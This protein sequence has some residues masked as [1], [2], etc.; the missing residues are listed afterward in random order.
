MAKKKSE[1]NGNLD[2]DFLKDKMDDNAGFEDLNQSTSAIPFIRVLQDLSPQVRSSKAEYIADAKAG[3]IFNTITEK[4]YPLPLRVIV[5]QFERYYIEWKPNRG[6]FVAV[7]SVDYVEGN[8]QLFVRD[9]KNKLC[10]KDTG[11]HFV[12]TYVYYVLLP[13]HIE[14]DVCIIAMSA[15]QIKVARK[16]NRSLMTQYIPG[17]KTKALPFFSIW[18]LD[19][20]TVSNDQGEWFAPRVKF[21]SFVTPE[22]LEQVQDTRKAL[23][24]RT[25][26]FAQLE[27][28]RTESKQDEPAY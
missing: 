15:T 16:W 13:D 24:G 20:V 27:S 6:A 7:H 5:G 26:D 18:A 8:P 22:I 10:H 17:T 2:Y 9:D 4:I 28:E 19:T 25:T 1:T 3:D 12:E 14:D 23:P 21:D 11:N